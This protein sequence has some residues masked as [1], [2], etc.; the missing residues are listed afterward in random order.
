MRHTDPRAIRTA[1]VGGLGALAVIAGAYLIPLPPIGSVRDWGD[2]LGPWFPWAFFTVS[3]VVTIAP[4]PR[5]TFTVMSGVFFGPI[6]GFTGA[7]IASTVAAVAAFL[8]VRRVGREKVRPYLRKPIVRTIEYRLE[9]RGWLAI[10]SL[11]LIAACP[12][13]VTNYCAGLSSVRI[14]PY[15]VATVIGMAPGTAAV[16]FLGDALTGQRDPLLLVLTVIFFATGIAGLLLDSMLPVRTI[17]AT[18]PAAAGK[19]P[20]STRSGATDSVRTDS[21]RT[22]SMRAGS[23]PTDSAS[24]DSARTDSAPTGGA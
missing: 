16:V 22:D 3:A 2:G 18:S 10:G 12:F 9:Q 24:T 19:D 20:A 7:M 1:V 6:V 13:S 15:V 14:V 4:I 21:M 17:Q 8:V 5:S 11:R 23:M